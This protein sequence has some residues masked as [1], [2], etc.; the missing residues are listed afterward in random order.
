MSEGLIT[1]HR[2]PEKDSPNGLRVEGYS[3]DYWFPR[4]EQAKEIKDGDYAQEWQEAA[5]DAL[6]WWAFNG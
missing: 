4:P 6:R 2:Q 3:R 1:V 5:G